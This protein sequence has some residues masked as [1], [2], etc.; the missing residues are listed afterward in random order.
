[1]SVFFFFIQWANVVWF[2]LQYSSKYILCFIEVMQV[3][4]DRSKYDIM[5]DIHTFLGV[6]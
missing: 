6:A 4:S 5:S 2:P 1:M 3:W